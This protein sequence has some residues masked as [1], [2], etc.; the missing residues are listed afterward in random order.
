M[1]P[2][3]TVLLSDSLPCLFAYAWYVCQSYL[4]TNAFTVLT[5]T[6]CL[7]KICMNTFLCKGIKLCL[8]SYNHPDVIAWKNLASSSNNSS[9]KLVSS[10]PKG[11]K[12]IGDGLIGTQ[13]CLK[14]KKNHYYLRKPDRSNWDTREKG[15]SMYKMMMDRSTDLLQLKQWIEFLAASVISTFSRNQPLAVEG[16]KKKKPKQNPSKFNITKTQIQHKKAF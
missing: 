10:W 15:N 6:F 3:S 5:D 14:K 2:Y 8:S 4:W 16:K 9:D 11:S 7:L 13:R 1:P 12:V